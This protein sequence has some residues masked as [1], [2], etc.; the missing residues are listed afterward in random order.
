LPIGEAVTIPRKILHLVVDDKFIDAAIREFE[1]VAPGC[2]EFVIVG[3][4][5]PFRFLRSEAIRS[6]TLSQWQQ[7]VAADDVAAV[8]LHSLPYA[9]FRL[10][11]DLPPGPLVVW[12]GWGYDYYGLL[13]DAFPQGY[14]MPRTAALL[15]T[16]H[17][18]VPRHQPGLMAASELSVTRP[19]PRPTAAE[20]RVLQRVDV[21]SALWEEH[22]L[23]QRHASW[24]TPE[25]VEW[26]YMTKEDDLVIDDL[27]TLGT[28]QDLLVGNS[29][30][31]CN[32][33]I[34]A[35][36]II[37]GRIDLGGRRVVVPL[38]YGD[39]AYAQAVAKVGRQMF[40]DAFVPLCGYLQRSDYIR[41]LQGCGTVLMNHVRQQAVGNLL[42]AGLL[43]ASLFVNPHS[44]LLRW[45][46]RQGIEADSIDRLHPGPPSPDVQQR[47]AEAITKFASRAARRHLTQALVQ[48]AIQPRRLRLAA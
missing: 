40:G 48:R 21:H 15:K 34:E 35:F 44:P 36:E 18:R 1:A 3:V 11:D 17:P 39:P 22:C 28:R 19:Y 42:I 25:R 31:P 14:V 12:L 32:N 7:R 30:S 24:F 47:N 46:Y 13:A 37:R 2:H 29:A 23:L 5:P 20:R 6:L 41:T 33:H 8:F 38:S 10:V 43:G 45:L 9:H 27:S 16:L 4:A 26:M